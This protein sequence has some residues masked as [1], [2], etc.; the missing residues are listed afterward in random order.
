MQVD[1]KV[2]EFEWDKGN[3]EKNLKHSVAE[4]EAEEA[5]LDEGKVIYKDKLHSEK[6]ER[7][8]LLGKTKKIRLLYL[9]FT[10]RKNKIRIISARDINKKEVEI[11][12][13]TS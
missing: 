11:Y 2:L 13:K 1:K 6:E 4:K 12:E 9:V 7:F 10:K 8:I 3:I 5:F